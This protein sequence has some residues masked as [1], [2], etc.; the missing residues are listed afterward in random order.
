[1]SHR[2]AFYLLW[3]FHTLLHHT[4]LDHACCE[5][6][7]ETMMAIGVVFSWLKRGGCS[8]N[9]PV[10]HLK[11][12]T[13]KKKFCRKEMHS[14][15]WPTQLGEGPTG[16]SGTALLVW[17]LARHCPGCSKSLKW[18]PAGHWL[19]GHWNG[20]RWVAD[21]LVMGMVTSWSLMVGS[22]KWRLAS[23]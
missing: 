7:R 15:H 13:L 5:P 21:G 11:V 17:S 6:M 20:N 1:M 12:F 23:P 18:R 22:L 4:L 16:V 9:S 14:C 10:C 8:K 19:M 2:I 3:L